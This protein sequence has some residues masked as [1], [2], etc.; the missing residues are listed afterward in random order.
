MSYVYCSFNY[1]LRQQKMVCQRICVSDC[2]CINKPKY[3]LRWLRSIFWRSLSSSVSK[4]QRPATSRL[5]WYRQAQ[6]D[7]TILVN[8]CNQKYWYLW[9]LLCVCKHRETTLRE[10]SGGRPDTATDAYATL[11]T[12]RPPEQRL[13][14]HLRLDQRQTDSSVYSSI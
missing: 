6:P 7:L 3:I 4:M 9:L 2:P 12:Q 8:F 10:S 11:S 13:Y 14:D 5:V 1:E